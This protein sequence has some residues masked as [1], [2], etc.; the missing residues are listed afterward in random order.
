VAFVAGVSF[1]RAA[2]YYD[3]TR[4][5][6]ERV[7]DELADVLAAELAGRGTCLEVG[8]GT[9]RIALPLDRRGIRLAG[10]DIAPAMLER[11]VA[12]AG[13]RP[14][15]L[16]LADATRLPMADG[17]FGAVMASHVLHLIPD[18]RAAVDEAVRVLGPGG[19]LLAD[20]G[21]GPRAPWSGPAHELMKRRR[22]VHV[23]PGVS[24]P[25]AVGD[26]LGWRASAR[27]LPP[28]T[29]T[30][31]R[32]LRQDLDNWERQIHAWTWPYSPGDMRAACRD[33]QD[34][35][36]GHGWPLGREVELNRVIQWWAFELNG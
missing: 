31:R 10:T 32:S 12:N 1:D 5:L 30:V 21:G 33:I 26:H 7:R 18:W 23:R 22:I 6:P 27:K 28:V 24:D 3:A 35:A 17:S 15:P 4:S 19:L 29:M 13:G 2:G 34:W 14:F 16:L 36:A 8:V 25:L 20:F 11:L 9:G